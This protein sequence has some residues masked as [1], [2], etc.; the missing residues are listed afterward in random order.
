[1][2][3]TT[4]AR[5]CSDQLAA[6]GES[7]VYTLNLL[8]EFLP[9]LGSATAAKLSEKIL[10]LM[11][12]G[13]Q[14]VYLGCLLTFNSLFQASDARTAFQLQL[15]EALYEY[16]P[17]IA[18]I[19]P[20]MAWQETMVMAHVALVRKKAIAG[21]RALPRLCKSLVQGYVTE[22]AKVADSITLSMKQLILQCLQPVQQV[23]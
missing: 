20:R 2:C 18:D 23:Q 1:M 19:G 16:E 3:V 4:T 5:F 12:T 14:T 6:G 21:L 17:S 22:R 7:V 15:T 8:I 10:R 9:F 13:D 11:K